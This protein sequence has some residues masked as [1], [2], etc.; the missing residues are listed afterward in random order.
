M[1]NESKFLN[2]MKI[3]TF[4]LSACTFSA[5]AVPVNSQTAKVTIQGSG[6]TIGDFINQVEQQTDYLFVYSKNEVNTLERLNLKSGNKSVAHFLKEFNDCS[7]LQYSFDND[8]IVLTKNTTPV[9]QQTHKISGV[10]K[11]QNGEPVIGANVVIKGTTNGTITDVDGKFALDNVPQNAVLDVS[12]LGY[13][14]KEIPVG[15]DRHFDI[16]LNEDT[17]KLDE[18]VVTALGIKRQKRSIGYSTANVGSEQLTESRDPNLGNAL[19]GKIAGVSVAGNSTGMSGS[20]RVVIRGN[21][22]LTGNNQPLY[23]ID[24][25]PFD[26]SNQGS[27]GQWG[28]MDMGDGLNSI[29]ADDIEEI[30][31]LKGAAASALYG[32]RGGNGAILITT[33]SGKKRENGLG[34][35]FNNNL[36]FNTIYD[37]RDYQ[38]IYGQGT[39]GVKPED[40]TAAYNTYNSSW[41]AKMDGST[42]INRLGESAPYHYVDNWSR[43]YRTGLSEQAS[44]SVSN[45]TDNLSFRFGISDIEEK[46]NLP[47]AHSSQQGLNMNVVYDITSRLHL[48]VNGNYV[49]EKVNGRSN[50]S[51]GNG[52]TNATLLYL[53]N[54]Y[55]VRWLKA[56]KGMDAAGN[57][58]QPGN[59]VYFNN[60]YWLQYRKTN[61]SNKSRLTGAV[62]L[63]YDITDWLYAQGQVTRDGWVMDFKQVQPMGAAADPNGYLSEYEKNYSEMNWN[64]L[65]GFNKRFKETFSVNAAIGGNSLRNIVKYYG[66]DGIRP[67]I[68]PGLHSS[69]NVEANTRTY[70]HDYTE[71]QVRSV[72]GTAEFGF[73]DWL[74]VNFTGRNDWFSTLDPHN[75]SFFYPSVS[76][77]WLVSDCL[78]VPEWL[79]TAKLRAS[80]AAAS[81][82]T[83]PYQTALTYTT[84]DFTVDGQS[85]GTINNS[86]V[87]NR[88]LKP[89]QISEK[90]VGANVAFFGNRLSLDLAWY[91]KQTKDDIARVTTSSASGFSSAYRNVGEIQNQGFEFMVYGVAVKTRDFQWNS[92][93]NFAYNK[94]KVKY[95]GDGVRALT[96]EGAYSRSGNASIQCIVGESYGKIVGYTYKTDDAGNRIYNSDGLPV[97]SDETQVLGDGVYK[98]T[99]GFR[100]EFM[101]KNLF[102]SF[103]LD[104]KFGAKLFSGTNYSLY[105]TGLHKSTLEGREDGVIGKGI[106]EDG[107]VNTKSVDAQTYWQWIANQSITEEFVYNASFIKLRELSVGY[108]FPKNF[109]RNSLP[110][111]QS[112]NVSLVGRNLWTIMKHTP[113]I[114][115]ESAYNNSNGQ[116]LELNGYPATRNIGFNLNIK[117]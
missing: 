73:K 64:Y 34:I 71:F 3:S 45:K 82:G 28:G 1:K 16:F 25:I 33:K 67:F 59:N 93:L 36:T 58:F 13:M 27:A 70:T 29:N 103:L 54:G 89:V 35:E 100:N 15:N 92:S 110:F 46:S 7:G 2:V 55:D 8:Y 85:M 72:Y 21:A 87:P 49:F 11:D 51:D 95:L 24:G 111:I 31:V 52:N 101:Y 104:F 40:E 26:N 50:L 115:P 106:T 20:S 56:D 42:F 75:N 94:S 84:K 74:F 10:V 17:Q 113:N 88:Y 117:F 22:S 63:R 80:Y 98:W 12:Y 77:S 53:A 18:V 78:Q 43:F 62:T 116:G 66:A 19:S 90:E 68:I 5:F 41:G 91:D 83:S 81:N 38:K 48:S 39:Q 23:V 107:A 32:Y 97:R 30:Q 65:V 108:Q 57:E 69:T 61:E 4:M 37:F 9:V 86:T 99:G 79:T 105:S 109:L 96:I 102:L 44:L 14:G 76:L 114:D 6:I 112:M 60:P 47:N